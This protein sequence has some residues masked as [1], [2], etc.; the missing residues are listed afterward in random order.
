M[1]AA[2]SVGRGKSRRDFSK[3]R[4]EQPTERE[5]KKDKKEKKNQTRRKRK[6]RSIVHAFLAPISK[7]ES[8]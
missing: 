1:Q 6:H 4:G 7:L 5:K 8:E 2:R 3:G